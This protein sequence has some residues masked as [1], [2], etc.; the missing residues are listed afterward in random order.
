MGKSPYHKQLQAKAA[1]SKGKTEVKIPG[2]RLLD[3]KNAV[4][5]TAT[6]IERSGKIKEALLRLKTQKAIKKVLQVPNPQMETAKEIAEKIKM[7][8]L[9]KN[10]SGTKRKI[11]RSN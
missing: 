4:T 11:V 5:N 8:V 7:N 3:A 9:I 1:G 2:N 10:L 6:E